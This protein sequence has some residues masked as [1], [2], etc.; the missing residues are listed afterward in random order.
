MN[1]SIE[2]LTDVIETIAKAQ[3]SIVI[4]LVN[5][6]PPERKKKFALENGLSFEEVEEFEGEQLPLEYFEEKKKLNLEVELQEILKTMFVPPKRIYDLRW[7]SHNLGFKN[8]EHLK[9]E[10]ALLIIKVLLVGQDFLKEEKQKND[11]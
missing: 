7:L 5:S 8:A 6:L 10:R 11:K 1:N 3:L 2:I 4:Q 9:F